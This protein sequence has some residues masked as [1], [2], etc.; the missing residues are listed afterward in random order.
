MGSHILTPIDWGVVIA[1]FLK[2][3]TMALTLKCYLCG[4]ELESYSNEIRNGKTVQSLS[5]KK[6]HKYSLDDNG[7]TQLAQF[8][9][10]F[11]AATLDFVEK[12]NAAGNAPLISD[13]ASIA[14]A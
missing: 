6:G 3:E 4:A 10:R 2:G 11:R 12:D 7:L 8:S 13:L 1:F 9:R 14:E 5:C